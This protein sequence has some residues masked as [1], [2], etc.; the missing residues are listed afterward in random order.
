M[1]FT[2]LKNIL[3][4]T[5]VILFIAFIVIFILWVSNFNIKTL[6]KL[7]DPKELRYK[8]NKYTI[9]KIE[10]IK[11]NTYDFQNIKDATIVYKDIPYNI[12]TLKVNDTI[13][14]ENFRISTT[15]ARISGSNYN[16]KAPN[17]K[18]INVNIDAKIVNYKIT[19]NSGGKTDNVS[20]Q[21][22]DKHKVGDVIYA[23]DDF[24]VEENITNDNEFNDYNIKVEED[25]KKITE[26]NKNIAENNKKLNEENKQIEEGNKKNRTSFLIT[27]IVLLILFLITFLIGLYI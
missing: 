4:T 22:A 17:F 8:L 21:F 12:S 9:S 2:K 26:D 6:K 20:I 10:P 15:T 19:E 7:D 3:I 16:K 24:I 18:V 27:W 25:N 13:Y 11:V 5:S 23:T 14:L 1:S